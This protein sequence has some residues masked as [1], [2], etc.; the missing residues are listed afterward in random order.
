MGDLFNTRRCRG[1]ELGNSYADK[2]LK[3]ELTKKNSY[4]S[5]INSSR[6]SILDSFP[7]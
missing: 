1:P 5:A 7:C 4:T 3:Y 2:K 6:F